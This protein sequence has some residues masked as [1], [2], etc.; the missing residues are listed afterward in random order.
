[1][2][3]I[4]NY[5]VSAVMDE[6]GNCR[7]VQIQILSNNRATGRKG[8]RKQYCIRISPLEAI[9]VDFKLSITIKILQHRT[10]TW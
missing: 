4:Q 9:S 8:S 5:K 10:K 6:F 3:S 7:N 1:M 2:P